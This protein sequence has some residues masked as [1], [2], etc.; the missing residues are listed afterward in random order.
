MIVAKE[1]SKMFGE[2]SGPKL[3]KLFYF[4]EALEKCADRSV[5]RG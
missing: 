1:L 4:C 3:E 2:L 5:H